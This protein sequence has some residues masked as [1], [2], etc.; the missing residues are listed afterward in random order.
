MSDRVINVLVT[1]QAVYQGDHGQDI[2]TALAVSADMTIGALVEGALT[3]ATWRAAGD[4]TP[5]DPDP[6]AYVTIRIA[7]PTAERTDR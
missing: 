4:H 5:A 1:R 7:M 2:T 6:D 3:K